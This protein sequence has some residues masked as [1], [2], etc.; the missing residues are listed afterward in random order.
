MQLQGVGYYPAIE[1][2]MELDYSIKHALIGSYKASFSDLRRALELSVTSIYLTS[3][4]SDQKKAIEWINSCSDTPF[5]SKMLDKLSKEKRF[6]DFNDKYEWVKNLKQ[7]YWNLSNFSHNKGRLNG[8]QQLNK[9]SHR[10]RGTIDPSIKL[11]TLAFF[12]DF[13]IKTVEEIVIML[14]LYNP[15]ILVGLPLDEKFGLNPPA[16]GFYNDHQSDLIHKLIPDQFK[17]YFIDIA[18]NDEDIKCIIEWINSRPDLTDED[19]EEQRRHMDEL[20]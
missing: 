11:E 7:F 3:N 13:Y 16:S 12:C 15:V 10:A 5:F 6:K 18:N 2:E 14:A 9:I 19:F 20:F 4:Q 8:Y 17:Q 1:T